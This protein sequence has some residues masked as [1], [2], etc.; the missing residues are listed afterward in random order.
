MKICGIV[1]PEDA[2]LAVAAGA[3][4]LGIIQCQRFRRGVSVE[5]SKQ[6]AA[7]AHKA[8]IP[9]VGVFVYE[10][11][12]EISQ[13]C[14]QADLDIAQLHGDT[15]RSALAGLPQQLQVIYA[16]HAAADGRL[17]TSLPDS[18]SNLQR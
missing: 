17:Q 1:H 11:A 2:E 5:I 15:A 18:G 6:I 10:G 12:E 16:V 3:S 7:I 9:A 14:L 13:R 4:F 8:G